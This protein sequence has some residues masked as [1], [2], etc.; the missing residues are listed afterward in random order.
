LIAFF[1][2]HNAPSPSIMFW[3]VENHGTIIL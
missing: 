3:I 1:I 2:H